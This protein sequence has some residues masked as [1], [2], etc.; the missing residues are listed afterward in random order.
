MG[1]RARADF[2]R[3]E[4]LKS[5]DPRPWIAYGRHLLERG[6]QAEADAA[7]ADAARLTPGELNRFL[8]AGWWVAGPY[9][10]DFA[11]PCPPEQSPDPSKPVAAA[12]PALLT[13]RPVPVVQNSNIE[14]GDALKTKA[15]ESAY[16][17]NYVYCPEDRAATLLV[18][19]NERTRLWVNGRF[20]H[21]TTEAR[22]EPWNLDRV[23][24]T[25]KAG[26]NTILARVLHPAV[27]HDSDTWHVLLCRLADTPEDR[28]ID[29]GL[30]GLWP[31]AAAEARRIRPGPR[32]HS[33][34][35]AQRAILDLAVGDR[36]GYEKVRREMATRPADDG[37][38]IWM[39]V[40]DPGSGFPMDRIGE[41]A[42]KNLRPAESW[43]RHGLAMAYYRAGRFAES[44][45]EWE[46][47][48]EGAREPGL[49]MAY[50]RLGRADD[51]ERVL[52]AAR[53]W[54]KDLIRSFRDQPRAPAFVNWGWYVLASR[55]ILYD[56]AFR[57]IRGADARLDVSLE[58]LYA[59]ARDGAKSADPA[60]AE[61]DLAVKAWPDQPRLHLA[62]AVRLAGLKR[63][64]E[65]DE[66]FARAVE[67]KPD[68]PKVWKARGRIY[69]EL[70]R[71]AAAA[72]DFA[73]YLER[74]P[75]GGSDD[76]RPKVVAELA[77]WPE[78]FAELVELRPADR[79]LV[80]GRARAALLRSRWAAAARDYRRLIE[81]WPLPPIDQPFEAA[82]AFLLSGDRRGYEGFCRRLLDRARE[83]EDH[84]A[85][86]DSI[87]SASLVPAFPGGAKELVRIAELATV[88]DPKPWYIHVL[89]LANLRAGKFDDAA[90]RFEES[91]AIGWWSAGPALNHLGLALTRSKQGRTV[92][93]RRALDE[94]VQRMRP[95][96][97]IWPDAPASSSATDWAEYQ[98]LLGEAEALILLDPVFPADPFAR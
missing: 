6:R 26:R 1:D 67:L 75:K 69:A 55:S 48:D 11:I 46:A 50:H 81:G 89:G 14:L 15:G 40:L 18:G 72:A 90:G 43:T 49:A 58:P 70:G 96:Q 74:L 16:A 56:E 61:F 10:G 45:A 86:F 21:E 35:L 83:S 33:W 8:E 87:R 42:K 84:R 76:P 34:W 4:A 44:A 47:T 95:F 37:N 31:E 63:D 71:P 79:D 28:V 93:A 29:L 59:A 51:A 27:G 17:L 60:T 20:V 13:W 85:Q 30:R 98:L 78:A 38:V 80:L 32:Q 92:E 97:P 36:E 57:L 2:A 94:A 39:A 82:A 77:Q 7:L 73:R 19:G 68:D 25:L 88:A 64:R 3:F 23:P 53:D 9:P 66:D 24:V 65:A 91:L 41:G 22:G 52:A 12:G 54:L 5:T 62:R